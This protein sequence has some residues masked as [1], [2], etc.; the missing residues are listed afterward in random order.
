MSNSQPKDPSDCIAHAVREQLLVLDADLRVRAASKSFYVAFKVGPDE[1]LGKKL[2]ELGNGQWNIPVLL[3][4]LKELPNKNGEFD[5]LE[6]ENDFPLVGHRTN[7]LS[8]RPL[9]TD[10]A[11]RGMIVLSIWDITRQKQI[12]AEVG[13]SL[14][15]FRTTLSS[16]GDA[17]IVT[18]PESRITFMNP[19]AERLTGWAQNEALQMHLADIFNIVSEQ[20]AQA[21]ENPVTKAIRDGAIVG[22]ANHTILI[23]RDGTKWPIDDSAAP[24][25]GV[26]GG[27]V[28]VV[29]VFHDVSI[30]RKV[31]QELKISE[32]RYRRL[33]ESA[34]DG[35][36]ILDAGTAKVLEV[37]RFMLDL[38]GL[39]REHFLGKELWEIGVFKDAQ[40]SKAAVETLQKAGAIRYEDLPLQHRDGRHIPVE[41]VSN[42]YR[43]GLR[44]VIQCN[45]RD[46]SERKRVALEL[47][48]AKEDAEAANRSKSQ[49]LANMSHE[50][51]TPMTAILGFA[52]MLLHKTPEECAQAG[53]VQIIRRNALHLLELINE[54]LDLSKIEA[55]HMTVERIPCD[56][57]ALLA[58]IISLMRPRAVEK[59]LEFGVRFEG[60]IPQL[61][62]TDP[63]RLRQ[64]LVN[65]LGNAVK[66][67][68]SGKIELRIIDE[69]AGTPNILLRIDVIDTGIGMSPVQVEQL[70]RAFTQGEESTT[71][72]YGGTGLGLTISR[73]FARLLKGDV[74][75]TSKLGSGSSFSL[76]IDGGDS[77]GVQKLSGLT[78][79]TLPARNDMATLSS[80]RLHGR[81]L[82]VE[83]GRDN[84]R[85]L[86][87]QLSD[88]GATVVSAENGQIAIDLATTQPFDLILMDMQ[89]PIMDGYVATVELRRTGLSTPIIALTAYAMAEDREKCMGSGCT[90]YLS[91]PVDEETL[92]RTVKQHLGDDPLASRDEHA[93]AEI[94]A[95][96]GAI[97]DVN[98]SG[99]IKSSLADNPRMKKII[100]E[101]V[102][103]LPGEV[104]KMAD[105]LQ[106]N[107]LEA[108]RLV[109]HQLLGA[110]GGYGF[111]AVSEPAWRAETLI[112]EGKDLASIAAQINSLIEIIRRIDGY[113]E[114]KAPVAANASTK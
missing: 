76:T 52:E 77:A 61:I 102:D 98:S 82:L 15:R 113:D 58:E 80:T 32:L 29:L 108:L 9:S 83:D 17:V 68:E 30:G 112:K 90:A 40:S 66:F 55:G 101:F 37:N 109:V 103:G 78:E 33:F 93:A 110:S 24:I 26:D 19:T 21:V 47:A 107:E 96:V 81:I 51:R 31:E 41:F 104:R 91:K 16:I 23:A 5:D 39:P 34:H 69:G 49:F 45:I 60:P 85:L 38:L 53:C 20:T 65:L 27:I 3:T 64:I 59:R 106:R 111:T 67:T 100:P 99:R 74:T 105:L 54:I 89:M 7:L 79:A 73:R 4:R 2:A 25:H 56:L 35:I 114:S 28:G 70:F 50:I 62:Q 94:A 1:T 12:E 84:Q 92:L 75:V 14:N 97:A 95:P 42:V 11:Q 44:D 48:K 13:D 88:A 72:K 6:I 87:M 8:A 86:R 22:L 36:L 57:P 63:L 43:E 71:R 10:E 46:I 18:D